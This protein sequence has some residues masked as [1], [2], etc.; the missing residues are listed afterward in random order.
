MRQYK[1]RERHRKFP[2]KRLKNVSPRSPQKIGLKAKVL[3]HKGL[4]LPKNYSPNTTNKHNILTLGFF[5][6]CSFYISLIYIFLYI[7][8]ILYII[9]NCII[10]N[11][12]Q[13]IMK[14]INHLFL[15]FTQ[16]NQIKTPHVML[17]CY[18]MY[19]MSSTNLLPCDRGFTSVRLGTDYLSVGNVLPVRR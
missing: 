8:Y 14:L 7:F 13:L 17:L 19:V 15:P 9:I 12:Y 2:S 6:N 16:S 11:Y 18:V 4:Y 5:Y 3:N 10:Y 1:A